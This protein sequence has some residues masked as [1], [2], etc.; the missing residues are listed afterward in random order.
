MRNDS[1]EQNTRRRIVCEKC[2]IQFLTALVENPRTN[3][4]EIERRLKHILEMKACIQLH[5]KA[6]EKLQKDPLTAV[7][8]LSDAK[9]RLAGLQRA[10]NKALIAK[11][12]A[13]YI[14]IHQVL[15]ELTNA[16][17]ISVS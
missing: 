5:E 16:G 12:I 10:Q 2:R 8:D 1:S 6:I 15:E 9:T 4:P 17:S 11:W 13:E 3:K 14:E 7:Q